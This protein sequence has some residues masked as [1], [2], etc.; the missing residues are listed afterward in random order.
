MS[1]WR[2][3]MTRKKATLPHEKISFTLHRWRFNSALHLKVADD[4]R[5]DIFQNR[6]FSSQLGLGRMLL[7]QGAGGELVGL[8][9]LSWFQD[10]KRM[11]QWISRHRKKRE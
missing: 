4:F 2:D 6:R 10:P 8:T 9:L 11:S 3:N 1:L 7:E 5:D